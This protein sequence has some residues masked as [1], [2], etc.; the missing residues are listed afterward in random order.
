M[1]SIL[2]LICNAHSSCDLFVCSS[3][4]PGPDYATTAPCKAIRHLHQSPEGQSGRC[5][6]QMV[7]IFFSYNR[8]E[9]RLSSDETV[10]RSQGKESQ[11]HHTHYLY[12]PFTQASN[13]ILNV[14]KPAD[15]APP[16]ISALQAVQAYI[17]LINKNIYE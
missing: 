4:P 12:N 2:R 1:L 13:Q 5:V 6:M 3:V 10:I 14:V 9:V 11:T 7:M 8:K 17:I 16:L 15:L